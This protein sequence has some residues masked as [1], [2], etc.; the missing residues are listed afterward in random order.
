MATIRASATIEFTCCAPDEMFD[1]WDSVSVQI[2]ELIPS[3]GL[4][5]EGSGSVGEWCVNCKYGDYDILSE[6]P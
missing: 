3:D 2:R 4:P 1:D 6:W 5:C